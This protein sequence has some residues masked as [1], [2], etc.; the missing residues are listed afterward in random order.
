[1]QQQTQKQKLVIGHKGCNCQGLNFSSNTIECFKYLINEVKTKKL[2]NSF[3][4]IEMDI[5]ET[6]DKELIVFHDQYF[7][8]KGEHHYISDYTFTEL[9]KLDGVCKLSD[10]IKYFLELWSSGD[11]QMQ[12]YLDIKSNNNDF[13]KNLT[14]TFSE[15]VN[16]DGEMKLLSKYICI[17]SF[18]HLLINNIKKCD[19]LN[20]FAVG[21]IL[22]GIINVESKYFNKIN[23]VSVHEDYVDHYSDIKKKNRFK[24]DLYLYTI[25][26]MS[27]L[28]HK[29]ISKITGIVTDFPIQF[30]E[31]IIKKE[32]KKIE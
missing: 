25:N 10:V 14:K 26:C 29:N 2:E 12:I 30:S 5:R 20:N 23:F 9:E 6:K 32:N 28:E 21:Y 7:I 18:N 8:V 24:W 15:C 11:T 17:G 27:Y 4:M 19:H 13:Y 1:M 22:D 3:R 31:R 16:L